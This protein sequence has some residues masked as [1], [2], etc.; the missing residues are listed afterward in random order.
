MR[1]HLT[2]IDQYNA[3]SFEVIIQWLNPSKQTHDCTML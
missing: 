2:A 1:D 3:K